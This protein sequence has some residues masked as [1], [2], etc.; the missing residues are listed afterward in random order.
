[1]VCLDRWKPEAALDLL[2]RHR[3]AWTMLVPTMALQLS[4]VA[5]RGGRAAGADAP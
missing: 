5:G 2:E 1:M 4:L 3:V